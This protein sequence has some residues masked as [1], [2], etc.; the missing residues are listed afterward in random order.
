MVPGKENVGNF[1]FCRMAPS[2][3][4]S[5]DPESQNCFRFYYSFGSDLLKK[6]ETDFRRCF[7]LVGLPALMIAAKLGCYPSREVATG[8]NFRYFQTFSVQ[9]RRYFV[10]LSLRSFDLLYSS[11]HV[12]DSFRIVELLLI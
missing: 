10:V 1:V 4:T 2:V 12:I 9:S 6:Y 8:T 7:Q 3:T 5:A 11:G